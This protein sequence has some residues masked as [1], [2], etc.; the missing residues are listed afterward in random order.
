MRKPWLFDTNTTGF[1]F[2]RSI[3]IELISRFPLTQLEGIHLI[4]SRWGHISL[5]AEDEIAYHESPE[6]W[7]KEFY[8]GT[9][10]VWWKTENDRVL[11]DLKPLK[12][13][14]DDK[15]TFYEL[16]KKPEKEE[17]IL[18]N[19]VEI[20]DLLKNHLINNTFKKTWSTTKYNYNEALKDFYKYNGWL[21]YKEIC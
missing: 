6:F 1:D 9:D 17:Y 15:E 2:C 7:A 13:K 5:V 19:R 18:V 11:M 4:N 8:W 20:N 10:T 21:E 3:L 14:R 12:P 16:W